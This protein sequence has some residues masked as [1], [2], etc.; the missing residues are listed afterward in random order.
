MGSVIAAV[1]LA[2]FGGPSVGVAA[3]SPAA[4]E[5]HEIIDPV[6]VEYRR[7]A[8]SDVVDALRL[9]LPARSFGS[10]GDPRPVT[11]ERLGYVRLLPEAEGVRLEL[12]LW[13]GRAFYRMLPAD[14]AE[15]PREAAT[16]LVNLLAGIEAGRLAPDETGVALPEPEPELEPES[17]LENEPSTDLE[18]MPEVEDERVEPTSTAVPRLELGVALA[19][20][21]LFGLGPPSAPGLAA[22][23]AAATL[24]LRWRS[25]GLLSF[26]VRGIGRGQHG[27]GL[28]RLRV[29]AGGGVAL[30][31]GAFELLA[32]ASFDVEPWFVRGPDGVESLEPEDGPSTRA[33]VL[34]GGH[35][36]LVPAYR[37]TLGDRGTSLRI[38][39]RLDVA[40]GTTTAGDGGIARIRTR[41]EDGTVR[42][43][44]RVGALELAVGLE[45]GLWFATY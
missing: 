36:R 12:I 14:P 7:G 8:V 4:I 5:E 38:G 22:G 17:Q 41:E 6:I 32:T 19:P 40:G 15:T 28:G 20:S 3:T 43:V 44:F 16:T 24:D 25:G 23:G 11:P 26:G 2:L 10:E 21:L 30:R 35:L 31:R 27:Y 18:P 13:D 1:V 34:L 37:R 45:L 9:R 39:P 29:S 42:D 33:A